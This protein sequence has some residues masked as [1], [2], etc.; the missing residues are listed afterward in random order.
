MGRCFICLEDVTDDMWL[1]PCC[2]SAVCRSHLEHDYQKAWQN[3][4]PLC[5]S[6]GGQV[7][8]TLMES[9]FICLEG[10]TTENNTTVKEYFRPSSRFIRRLIRC[11]DGFEDECKIMRDELGLEWFASEQAR[12]A[13]KIFTANYFDITAMFCNEWAKTSQL[14]SLA[15]EVFTNFRADE[16]HEIQSS[17]EHQCFQI[18]SALRINY[19]LFKFKRPRRDYT[20]R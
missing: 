18:E 2:R 8:L 15:R 1:T 12:R 17:V 10:Q 7:E 9:Y 4:C 19:V 5:R 11:D 16:S 6:T 14:G 20:H 3:G 13:L